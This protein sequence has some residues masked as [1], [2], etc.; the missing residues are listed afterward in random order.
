MAAKKKKEEGKQGCIGLTDSV[1]KNFAASGISGSQ[2]S[3]VTSLQ[4]AKNTSRAQ[5]CTY[6]WTFCSPL[7]IVYQ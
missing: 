3:K 6:F 1:N 5:I 4:K 2:D 7:I